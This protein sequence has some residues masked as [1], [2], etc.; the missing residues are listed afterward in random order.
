ML[1][2]LETLLRVSDEM[3]APTTPLETVLRS[4]KLGL[5]VMAREVARDLRGKNEVALQRL[6]CRFLVERGFHAFG[7]KFGWSE[8]DLQ[9]EDVF[10]ALVIEAKLARRPPA[11]AL[12]VKWLSQLKSYMDQSPMKQR[13]ALVVFNFSAVPIVAPPQF[14]HARHLILP[15]NI[16]SVSPSKRTE[17]IDIAAAPAGSDNLVQIT[18]L[19]SAARTLNSRSRQQRGP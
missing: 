1:A 17:C 13:G 10:G 5:E 18:R 15:I 19:P 11:S 3:H 2:E 7:T 9:V 6:L 8:A 16:C 14:I 12:I 4:F